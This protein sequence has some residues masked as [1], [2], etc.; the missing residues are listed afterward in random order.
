NICFGMGQLGTAPVLVGAGGGRLR[1][2]SQLSRETVR[3]DGPKTL[4]RILRLARARE[5]GA[6]G[7][8]AAEVAHRAGYADQPHLSREVRALTGLTPGALLRG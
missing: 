7:L 6:T 8:S 5:L 3:P 2:D 1:R 4:A